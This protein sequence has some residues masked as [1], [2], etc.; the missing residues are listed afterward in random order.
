MQ[1]AVATDDGA[2]RQVQLAPPGDVGEVAEGA[3]HRDAGALVGLRGLV[4][5]DRDLDAEDR[6][7]DGGAEERLVALVVGVGDQRDDGGDQLGAGGLDAT[8]AATR[9]ALWNATRW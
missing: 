1:P 6:R 9:P 8:T 4:R 3:A 2:H 7:G 5:D